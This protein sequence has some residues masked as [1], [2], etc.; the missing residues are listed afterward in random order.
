MVPKSLKLTFGARIVPQICYSV[1]GVAIQVAQAAKLYRL[2]DVYGYV[3]EHLEN[4]L[5]RNTGGKHKETR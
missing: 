3:S 5:A 1:R 4:G 2:C